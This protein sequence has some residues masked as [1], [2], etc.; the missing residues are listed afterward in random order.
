MPCQGLDHRFVRS[1]LDAQRCRH[2]LGHEALV[3]KWRKFDHPRTIVKPVY[4]VRNC[5]ER[6]A[7]LANPAWPGHRQQRVP[8][9]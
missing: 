8:G 4:S 1:L 3:N 6:Q 7:T 5:L 9:K 2:D